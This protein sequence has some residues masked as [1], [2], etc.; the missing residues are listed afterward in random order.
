MLPSGYLASRDE[1]KRLAAQLGVT[2]RCFPHEAEKGG[3]P[4]LSTDVAYLGPADAQNLVIITS[5]THGVEGYAGAACQFHFMKAYPDRF[6]RNDV[7]WLLAHAVNPW[8]FL[9]DRRV[10]SEGVDL[11]RNFVDFPVLQET[12]S[13]YADYHRL[14]VVDY[15]PLPRGLWNAI[16]LLSHGRTR[17]QRRQL[18]DA[19]TGG[20]YDCPDG[21][22]F[23]GAAPTTSR[24]VWEDILRSYAGDRRPAVLLDLHTGLGQRGVGELISDLAPSSAGFLQ[25]SRW[26]G[27]GLRST[28]H[29]DS[30]SAAVEGSLSAAFSRMHGERHSVVLEFGTCGPLAVLNALRADQWY[31]NNAAELSRTEREWAR[32]KMKKAFAATDAEWHLRV[33]ARFD[34]VVK[35]LAAGLSEDR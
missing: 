28:L 11:N 9:H 34:Q 35:Q 32:R 21:L 26:F 6:A 31:F 20:Q 30:V 2:P 10:T 33:V 14:L 27:G 4:A 13:R 19:I 5:G 15:R 24:I 12:Q 29:G 1:F 18:R 3:S 17:G 7:A 16:R 8:G 25:L 22:F 23:G